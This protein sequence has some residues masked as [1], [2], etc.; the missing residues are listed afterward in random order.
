MKEKSENWCPGL[1]NLS[2]DT[3]H[4]IHRDRQAVWETSKAPILPVESSSR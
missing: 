3:R 2:D 1:Q 4:K